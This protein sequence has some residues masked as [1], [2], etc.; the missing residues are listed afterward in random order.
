MVKRIVVSGYFDPPHVG[1]YEL[2]KYAKNYCDDAYVV[3][4]IH[5]VDETIQKSGFYVY[6]T[7]ELMRILLQSP[8][9]D[10]V[11]TATD[12]D[13]TVTET[14]RTLK[15]HYFI[16]GPDRSPTTMPKKELEVCDEIGCQ[17]I[18]QTSFKVGNSS[19]IKKRI[20]EQLEHSF[21]KSYT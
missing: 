1:H 5:R 21:F 8:W 19:N 7:D 15:P 16:K 13:G 11:I 4:V 10:E 20:K 9:I 6:T 17:V 3:A 18:Y 14:L 12:I 2:F